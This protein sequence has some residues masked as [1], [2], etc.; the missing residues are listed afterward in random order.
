MGPELFTISCEPVPKLVLADES[1]YG[2]SFCLRGKTSTILLNNHD[3]CDNFREKIKENYN[4]VTNASAS[5]EIKDRGIT[6]T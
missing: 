6:P 4:L 5:D 3:A 1:W 2:T